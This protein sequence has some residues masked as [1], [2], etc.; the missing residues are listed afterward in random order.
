M[1]LRA[2]QLDLWAAHFLSGAALF[3]L[4]NALP[5][6]RQLDPLHRFEF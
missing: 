1:I 2:K 4:A 3:R 5:G 6:M